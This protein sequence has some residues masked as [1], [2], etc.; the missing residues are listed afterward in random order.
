MERTELIK[1]T[2][3]C[4]EKSLVVYLATVDEKG[5]P[6]IRALLNLRNPE[7][8][9][10]HREFFKD[11]GLSVYLS[12][13]TSSQKIGQIRSNPKVAAY[14]CLPDDFHGVMLSAHAHIVNDAAI[15]KELWSNGWE[16]YYPKG[17]TDPDYAIV[18]LDP[19]NA[20]GWYKACRFSFAV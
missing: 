12:T 10:E 20:Q 13:N 19:V 6:Y 7:Q 1:T 15:K 2:I 5:L 18:R 16:R 4:M 3:E 8:Y 11:K 9:P 17:V 14:F